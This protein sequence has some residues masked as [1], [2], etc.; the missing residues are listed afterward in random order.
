M[1]EY[2]LEEVMEE[3]AK[4]ASLRERGLIVTD[5]QRAMVTDLVFNGF[6][7]GANCPDRSVPSEST[8]R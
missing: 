8:K 7:G 1:P 6:F 2:L 3:G 4:Y 5:A